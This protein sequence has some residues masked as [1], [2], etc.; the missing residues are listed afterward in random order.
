M[1]RSARALAILLALFTLLSAFP[2]ASLAAAKVKT[3]QKNRWYNL[4]SEMRGHNEYK[5]KLSSDA[6]VKITW[7]NVVDWAGFSFST[8]P[9]FQTGGLC[10]ASIH[11]RKGSVCVALAKGTYYLRFGYEVSEGRA[12]PQAKVAVQKPVNKANYSKS[13]AL[14][15]SAGKTVQIAQTSN[16]SYERWYKIRLNRKKPVAIRCNG[17]IGSILLYDSGMNK[18]SCSRN[19]LRIKSK[20]SLKAGTYYI[21]VKVPN[22]FEEADGVYPFGY[23]SRLGCYI[24]L[25]WS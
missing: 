8:R 10:E 21:R 7:R 2:T 12:T 5:F 22:E 4:W 24:T 20:K 15:L 6:I 14:S 19:Y 25:K 9:S 16:N 17:Y 1:K 3:L 23:S 18:I 11:E 13:R